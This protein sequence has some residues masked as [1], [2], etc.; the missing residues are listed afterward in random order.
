[1][2]LKISFVGLHLYHLNY[3]KAAFP[4]NHSS[5]VCYR[6]V[7]MLTRTGRNLPQQLG[8][9]TVSSNLLN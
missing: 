2:V 1:V 3:S 4:T 8:Y 6:Y 5:P 7:R 9:Q